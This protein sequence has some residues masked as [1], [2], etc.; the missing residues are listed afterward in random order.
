M[1]PLSFG[2]LSG[3]LP[4][5]DRLLF[6]PESLDFLLDSDQHLLLFCS[7]VFISFF[8]PVLH[9]DLIKLGVALNELY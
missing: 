7:L 8:I 4:P 5:H 6:M 2:A 3:C 9:L 1:F